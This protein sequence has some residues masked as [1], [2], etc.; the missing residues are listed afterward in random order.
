MGWV[1]GA[2]TAAGGARTPLPA[3]TGQAPASPASPQ[4]NANA[5][6]QAQSPAAPPAAIKFPEIDPKNFTATTPTRET[7]DSFL[8]SVWGLDE[9]RQWRV[10]AIQPAAVAGFVRVEVFVGDKRQPTRV[11]N[12]SFMVT[13]DGKHAV[14]GDLA[15]FGAKPFEDMRTTLEQRADGPSRGA[16]SKDLELVEFADLQCPSCKAAQGTMDDLARDFPQARIVYQNLPLPSV[17]PFAMQAAEVGNCVRQSKGDA[18]FFAYAKKVYDAQA[19]LTAEKVDATLR[20]GVTAAG[21]DPAA[22]MTCS[23]QPAT[24]AAVETSMKLAS[25][26]GITGTPTLVV[27]GRALPLGQVPYAALKNVV[28]YQGK[29]DGIAVKEQPSLTTLK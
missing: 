9:N 4:S 15:P 29:L 3:A 13:P 14:Q 17:H 20:A 12:Y 19:D 18:A 26:L 6:T 24:R 21:A 16:A 1:A 28:V 25:D 8:H 27:N 11:G 5:A 22:V 10:T 7:V 2:Q 23:T